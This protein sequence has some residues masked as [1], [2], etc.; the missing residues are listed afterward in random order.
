MK[1]ILV[2]LVA[3]LAFNTT[4]AQKVFKKYSRGNISVVTDGSTKGQ[5][6]LDLKLDGKVGV[7]L[8]Q[9][10]R[11]KFMSLL[12]ESYAKYGEW[13]TVAKEKNIQ[14]ISNKEINKA[15]FRGFFKYGSWKFGEA[16][17]K[18]L[19]FITDGVPTCYLYVGKMVASDN[20]F[21]KS[22]S[23]MITLTQDIINE[24]KEGLSNES[25]NGF[26]KSLNSTDDLFN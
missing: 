19:F 3:V 14:S 21:M 11:E 17:I 10:D 8:K 18:T 6:Y 23:V 5:V 20:Q 26:I 22:E 9:K 7:S 4:N 2:L 15:T 16:N 25:I 12:T 1:K 24:L 13:V